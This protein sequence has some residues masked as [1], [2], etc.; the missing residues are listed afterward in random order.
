MHKHL[1]IESPVSTIEE[2][3][4]IITKLEI[5]EAINKLKNGKSP[6]I[7]I[8]TAEIDLSRVA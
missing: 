4:K 5:I 7:D 1:A 3:D 6:G 2:S 8:I